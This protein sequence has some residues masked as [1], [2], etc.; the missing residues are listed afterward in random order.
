MFLFNVLTPSL[1]MGM[2]TGFLAL[3]ILITFRL[4]NFTD[5]TCDGS[6]LI[7]ASVTAA[8]ADAHA[9]PYVALLL[10][11]LAGS[12]TGLLTA[13]FHTELKIPQIFSGILTAVMAYSVAL[14]IMDARPVI[15]L[16]NSPLL[17]DENFFRFLIPIALY[18]IIL[19]WWIFST[20]LGKTLQV[21]GFNPILA[22]QFGKQPRF[23]VWASLAMSNSLLALNGS[24]MT[25]YQQ[26]TDVNQAL[27]SLLMGLGATILGEKILP[28]RNLLGRMIA[29]FIGAIAYRLLIT[30][31]LNTTWFNLQPYDINLLMGIILLLSM[32]K[33]KKKNTQ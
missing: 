7:G 15:S 2:I 33:L 6:V 12:T 17:F 11:I 13:I 1:E 9:P 25:T 29:C 4:T 18:T 32:T 14:H 23:T 30:L 20:Q 28:V 24:L 8:L 22:Q 10:S 5:L 27:G 31:A 26:F 21:A 16:V 3:G 19:C